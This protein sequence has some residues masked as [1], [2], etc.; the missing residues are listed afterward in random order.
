MN[1]SETREVA[2]LTRYRAAGADDG[3]MARSLSALVRSALRASSAREI[4][5]IAAEWGVA[6]HPEFRC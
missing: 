2:K 4:R 6:N 5:D 1:K 3:M